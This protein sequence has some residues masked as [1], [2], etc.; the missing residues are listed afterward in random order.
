MSFSQLGEAG[1]ED[2]EEYLDD[3]TD[4][5][6]DDYEEVDEDY[7]S[8]VDAEVAEFLLALGL[9]ATDYLRVTFTTAYHSLSVEAILQ[10]GN[11]YIIF[12]GQDTLYEISL[13]P[14]I[15]RIRALTRERH[16]W[17]MRNG[18]AEISR[19]YGVADDFYRAMF[20]KYERF[21]KFIVP[22]VIA[23]TSLSLWADHNGL[24]YIIRGDR[25]FIHF[26][27]TYMLCKFEL[28]YSV[29]HCPFIEEDDAW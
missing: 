29:H 1:V 7:S 25:L 15:E 4:D 17:R 28:I 27:N 20:R 19:P 13:K 12:A 5:T 11:S 18:H 2:D 6:D 21:G 22:D 3:D 9:G 23:M 10:V 14:L 26:A 16:Q 24:E 8:D